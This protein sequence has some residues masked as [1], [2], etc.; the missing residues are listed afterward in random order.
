MNTT[1]RVIDNRMNKF[2]DQEDDE[3]NNEEITIEGWL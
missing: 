2:Y 1:K 3:L